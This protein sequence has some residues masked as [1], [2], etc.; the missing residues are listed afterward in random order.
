MVECTV[1]SYTVQKS[2]RFLSVKM[3]EHTNKTAQTN[4][5]MPDRCAHTETRTELHSVSN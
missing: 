5:T 1:R 2:I 4:T 3:Q